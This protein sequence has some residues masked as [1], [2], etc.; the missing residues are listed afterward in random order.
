MSVWNAL[1]ENKRILE[2][3]IHG[4]DQVLFNI[5]VKYFTNGQASFLVIWFSFNL[6]QPSVVFHIETSDLFYRVK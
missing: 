2:N 5:F 1:Q 6:F 4:K 3:T